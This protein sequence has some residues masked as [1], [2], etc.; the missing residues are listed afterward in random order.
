MAVLS[1]LP[2]YLYCFLDLSTLLSTFHWEIPAVRSA[3][4]LSHP[5]VNQMYQLTRMAKSPNKGRQRHIYGPFTCVKAPQTKI[6]YLL[7]HDYVI[8]Q[9][10][11]EN[12]VPR[13]RTRCALFAATHI[14]RSN[15]G[16]H[17]RPP[18][19]PS[20]IPSPSPHFVILRGGTMQVFYISQ[21]P[22]VIPCAI[23]LKIV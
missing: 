17:T 11:A 19:L 22:R 6:E 7:K 13:Y 4:P 23:I 10:H 5:T 2:A 8:P 14:G 15:L 21:T 18:F 1:H 20:P 9:T 3:Q 12:H 16:Y